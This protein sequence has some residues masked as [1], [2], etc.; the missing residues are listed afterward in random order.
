MSH[1][2][3]LLDEIT[4]KGNLVDACVES[5]PIANTSTVSAPNRASSSEFLAVKQMSDTGIA[6]DARASDISSKLL[7]QPVGVATDI[8]AAGLVQEI[9]DGVR[10]RITMNLHVGDLQ[11]LAESRHFE[12]QAGLSDNVLGTRINIAAAAI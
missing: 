9:S 7:E 2:L 5:I 4:G 10:V 12:F 8:A 6:V 3:A 11:L 1:K